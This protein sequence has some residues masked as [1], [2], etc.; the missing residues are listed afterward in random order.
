MDT[1]VS[2]RRN[3]WGQSSGDILGR[4]VRLAGTWAGVIHVFKVSGSTSM[5]LTTCLK[6]QIPRSGLSI[7]SPLEDTLDPL[8]I[9]L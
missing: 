5:P 4:S 1:P 6:Y 9:A 2:D 8:R 3:F 7:D